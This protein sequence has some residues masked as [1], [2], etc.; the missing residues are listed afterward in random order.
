MNAQS[1]SCK[2]QKGH[3][4]ID[5]RL[6][7]L[8]KAEQKLDTCIKLARV[9]LQVPELHQKLQGRT[10]PNTSSQRP[11]T[12]CERQRDFEQRVQQFF[13]FEQ[14]IKD[15]RVKQYSDLMRWTSTAIR[16]GR[17]Y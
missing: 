6:Q 15:L 8:K 1:R 5:L 2:D 17:D 14:A 16:K 11:Y 12:V 4:N 13:E 10:L 9:L 3:Q 7:C